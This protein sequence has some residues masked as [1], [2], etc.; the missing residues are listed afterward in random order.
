ML[1]SQLA[2]LLTLLVASSARVSASAQMPIVDLG[3]TLHIANDF[4]ATGQYY[5][6]NNIR[7]AKAPIGK[8]RFQAPVPPDV[9]RTVQDG[10]DISPVCP[11]ALPNWLQVAFPFIGAYLGGQKTFNQSSFTIPP[12]SAPSFPSNVGTPEDC[13]GLD[14]LVPKQ[15]FDLAKNGTNTTNVGA[16]VLVWIYGGGYTLGSKSQYGNPAGLLARSQQNGAP[17]VV[18]V[19]F[20]Y[21]LGAFGWL[22]GPSFEYSGGVANAA[23]YDQRL[24]L[25]WVKDNIAK[26]GGNPHEITVIGESAGAGSIMH[27]ITA[28]GGQQEALFQRAIVQS[29]ALRSVVSNVQQEGYYQNFLRL[30]NAS[31]FEE[32]QNLP[33][34]RV[35]TANVLQVQNS[36]YGTFTYG[37]VV[38]GIIAPQLPAQLLAKGQ[39][40]KNISVI[41][42]HNSLEGILFT[43]YYIN[44]DT[45]FRSELIK[46]L[47]DLAAFPDVVDY[48][49]NVLYPPVYDGSQ[50]YTDII[51]RTIKLLSER[52]FTCSTFYLDKAYKNQTYQYEFAV[53]P[54]IHGYDVSSTFYNGAEVPSVPVALDLQTYITSFALT[55]NPNAPQAPYFPQYGKNN[56]VLILNSTIYTAVDADANVR[57]DFWQKALFY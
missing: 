51:G 31:S 56:S 52:V 20:N 57:C 4:N 36:S 46:T 22:S 39:F 45:I 9:N 13:L 44:N 8:L 29:P 19:A 28:F 37:P 2:S 49:M 16:P 26:F 54:A 53:P 50:G 24:A 41:A 43:P 12:P 40:H 34:E 48:I 7:F 47:P 17:G 32:L 18:Y 6:F 3:Y 21:R 10:S 35:Q 33:Y 1:S 5:S 42:G 15:I 27:Q 30:A 14:V 23:L 38:D 25:K 11:S 55:G